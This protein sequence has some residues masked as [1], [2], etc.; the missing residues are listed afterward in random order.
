[1]FIPS[2]DFLLYG[3]WLFWYHFHSIVIASV[4]R[5]IL[6]LW[7]SLYASQ[8]FELEAVNLLYSSCL[9]IK[10]SFFFFFFAL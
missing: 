5:F 3:F 9:V 6:V 7:Q 2:C 10:D 1:M 8:R 4:I